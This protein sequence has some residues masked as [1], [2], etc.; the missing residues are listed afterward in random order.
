MAHFR[1]AGFSDDDT[2]SDDYGFFD[3]PTR[4]YYPTDY[5]EK[6]KN[7]MKL[8][9]AILNGN[10]KDV[11]DIIL[12]DLNNAVNLKLDSGWTPLMHA[13]FHAQDEIVRMLL[14][15]GADPNLHADSMTSVMAACSNSSASDYTIYNIVS[16]LIEKG[17]LLN[18]GD[19]LG[20][21]PLMR[22]ISNGRIGVVK[23]LLDKDVNIEMRD[24]QG[25]TALF[26]A[27]HHNQPE[28]V[29]LLIERGAR[30]AEVDRSGRT[31]PEIAQV[32]DFQA[33]VDILNR[34]LKREKDDND[35][36]SYIT[37][38]VTSWQDFYPGLNKGQRPSY[39]SEIP[40][41]LYGMNC[42]RLTPLFMDSG[43]DL[44]T[45]LLLEDKD[46]VALGIDM[47]Y[48]RQR[49]CQG[50]RSFHTRGWKLNA[51][52]GLYARKNENYSVID[53]LTTLGTHLQQ[54]YILEATLQYTLREYNRIQNQ[55]KYEPP[56]SP[57]LNKLK[58]AS[59][60]FQIN[61]NSIRRETK[62]MKTL[63]SK[64]SRTNPQPAD[65]IKE[66]TAQDIAIGYAKEFLIVCSLEEAFAQQWDMY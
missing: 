27:V 50:L 15:K 45:F 6:K 53:C 42:E 8:Q 43:M 12:Y 2:D 28:I 47:P 22:A 52:A 16:H 24:Q 44:R 63:L 49:L 21:T 3:K 35:K 48:E 23:L 65:L 41:L 58:A 36:E 57:L 29:E 40:H 60:K 31:L 10:L 54:L 64:I 30:L 39:V 56:D 37:S 51:V 61:I 19:K 20:Q 62:I 1:P 38:Q 18:I 17:C 25:W 32:H 55:I 4:A 46:M 9:D 14:D 66:K 34:H 11:E 13:C 26:W 7:E 5:N 59:K 33:I